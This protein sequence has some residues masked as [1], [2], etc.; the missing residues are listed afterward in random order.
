MMIASCRAGSRRARRVGRRVTLALIGVAFVAISAHGTSPARAPLDLPLPTDR[1]PVFALPPI[2]DSPV[3]WPGVLDATLLGA[4]AGSDSMRLPEDSP[5]RWTRQLPPLF[6]AP[7]RSAR[8]GNRWWLGIGSGPGGSAGLDRAFGNRLRF[9]AEGDAWAERIPD[10]DH[11][12]IGA[13][14]FDREPALVPDWRGAIDLVLLTEGWEGNPATRRA[15]PGTMR[16]TAVTGGLQRTLGPS[17]NRFVLGLDAVWAQVRTH[18]CP[19]GECGSGAEVVRTGRWRSIGVGVRTAG[20]ARDLRRYAPRE[21]GASSLRGDFEL[22][23][24][25]AHRRSPDGRGQAIGRWR[26][27]AVWDVPRG[28]WHLA[29]GLGASGEGERTCIAP[30]LGLRRAWLVSRTCAALEIAPALRSAEEV[31]ALPERLPEVSLIREAPIASPGPR[32]PVV[33]DPRLRPQR[34]WPALAG[35]ILRENHAG[36]WDLAVTVAHLRDPLDW[37]PDT[38]VEGTQLL[39]AASAASRVLARVAL[40]V[41]RRLGSS[42]V[43]TAR[44]RGVRDGRAGDPQRALHALPAHRLEAHLERAG[45]RWRWG[46]S[47]EAR[48]RAPAAAGTPA[49][50]ATIAIAA[51]AGLALGDSELRLIGENLFNAATC[52]EPYA[53]MLRRWV[54]LEWN[55]LDRASVP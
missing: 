31:L 54:G 8:E 35:E 22:W 39:R 6:P 48:G 53:P 28:A 13:Q 50:P 29:A 49:Q 3:V 2:D 15:L 44:Y 1:R 43:L 26:T 19:S 24:G 32:T 46:L 37:R 23:G 30:V 20:T 7:A 11:W 4:A 40:T 38:L 16:A 41:E 33:Y 17:T 45:S 42:F 34:A 27:R 9:R 36:G 10:R 25:V 21:G 52:D 55:L 47:A 5:A 14:L 12:R 18:A 51:H